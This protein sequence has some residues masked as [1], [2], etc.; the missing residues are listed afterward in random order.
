MGNAAVRVSGF[1]DEPSWDG[2]PSWEQIEAVEEL[3]MDLAGERDQVGIV[4]SRRRLRQ[5]RLRHALK[6]GSAHARNP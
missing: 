4:G 6:Q 1:P 5:R 2:K 3:L